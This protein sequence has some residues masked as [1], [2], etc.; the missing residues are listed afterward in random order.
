MLNCSTSL[1]EARTVWR[2]RERKKTRV[3]ASKLCVRTSGGSHAAVQSGK[4]EIEV[5]L[6]R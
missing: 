1:G 6:I 4:G 2:Q 5:I 3:V